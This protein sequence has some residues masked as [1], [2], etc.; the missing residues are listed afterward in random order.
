[1]SQ[2]NLG[3]LLSSLVKDISNARFKQ[4]RCIAEKRKKW[5]NQT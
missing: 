2:G 4:S 1:M 3:E 5:I